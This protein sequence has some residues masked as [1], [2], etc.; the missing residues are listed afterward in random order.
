[1]YILKICLLKS[2]SIMVELVFVFLHDLSKDC[3]LFVCID[4]EDIKF[5]K[6]KFLEIHEENKVLE[7]ENKDLRWKNK[8][9]ERENNDLYKKNR[10][11]EDKL[12][13]AN[14]EV[15]KK[16]K[17]KDL[18]NIKIMLFGIVVFSSLIV[19]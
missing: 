7:N 15:L 9:L 1:M 8:E 2:Y 4:E 13:K 10:D 5:Y 6:D 3:G 14:I 16:N 12:M 11:L 17:F 19:Y 18:V